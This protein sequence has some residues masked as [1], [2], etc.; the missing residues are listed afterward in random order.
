MPDDHASMQDDDEIVRSALERVD[1]FAPLYERHAMS[2]YRYCFNQT[3]DE[4][5]A[6]D[7]TAQ[8][9]IRAIERLHQ[10]TP[11]RG[12]TFRSWLFAIARNIVVDRWRRK[13]PTRSLDS[14]LHGVASDQ[15][16]PEEI[17]VHR[18]QVSLLVKALESLPD[19]YQD[20]VQLRLAGLTTSEIATSLGMTESAVKS[21]QTRAYRRLREILEPD[22]GK[23]NA[24]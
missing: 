5:I 20:I 9:F 23:R 8:I 3:R 18:S 2:I 1:D 10:Y 6:N 13:R 11:R 17:A 4:D 22:G 15:P 7:L 12:A 24:R 16:G 19:R 21:A 14:I